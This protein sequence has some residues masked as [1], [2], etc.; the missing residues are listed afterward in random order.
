MVVTLNFPDRDQ[1]ISYLNLHP[2]TNGVHPTDRNIIQ[3][4]AV[5]FEKAVKNEIEAKALL[6]VTIG[7]SNKVKP[8]SFLDVIILTENL[9]EALID[10]GKGVSIE[11]ALLKANN[12]SSGESDQTNGLSDE[13]DIAFA[14]FN[15]AMM[16]LLVCQLAKL[17]EK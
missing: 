7:D 12:K 6:L 14:H 10:C 9:T 3:E 5:I 1:I 13:D 2:A 4:I 11:D 17:L 15:Q 8:L 16:G